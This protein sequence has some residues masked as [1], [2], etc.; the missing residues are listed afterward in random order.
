MKGFASVMDEGCGRVKGVGGCGVGL[1]L[2]QVRRSVCSLGLV[3]GNSLQD[4]TA[5]GCRLFPLTVEIAAWKF[6]QRFNIHSGMVSVV[7]WVL[8]VVFH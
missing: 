1:V 8:P 3:V 5:P 6:I 4:A 7:C 2:G